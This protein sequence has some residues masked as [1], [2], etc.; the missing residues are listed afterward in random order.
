M[1]GT[2]PQVTTRRPSRLAAGQPTT[3]K[4]KCAGEHTTLMTGQTFEGLPTLDIDFI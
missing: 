2:Y 1:R 3:Q 4:E